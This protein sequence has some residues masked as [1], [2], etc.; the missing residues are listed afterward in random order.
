[1][2]LSQRLAQLESKAT[3]QAKGNPLP[4]LGLIAFSDFTEAKAFYYAE[5][6]DT[7]PMYRPSF[8]IATNFT[9][10]YNDMRERGLPLPLLPMGVKL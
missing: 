9:E 8:D 6:A 3:E 1:M 5:Q 2:S 10:L 4:I 7:Y